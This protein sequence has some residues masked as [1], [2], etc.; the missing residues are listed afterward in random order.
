[1]A[2]KEDHPEQTGT[3]AKEQ[4]KIRLS[5]PWGGLRQQSMQGISGGKIHQV[6]D[7]DSQEDINALFLRQRTRLHEV[8]IQ[9]EAK[10]KRL[11]LILGAAVFLAACGVILFAPAGREVTFNWI[12][13]AMLVVAA[14]IAGFKRVWGK[15]KDF[16][17]QADQGV[18]EKLGSVKKQS[19]NRKTK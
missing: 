10:T 6:S 9:E 5:V 18:A 4:P 16:Q 1:M 11:T 13:G 14:G 19:R 3:P 8:Y 12:G 17:L 2:E 15:T 7:S